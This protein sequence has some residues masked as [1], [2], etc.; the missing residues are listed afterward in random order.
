MVQWQGEDVEHQNVYI[1]NIHVKTTNELSD[2]FL[3]NI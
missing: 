2:D 1:T 3:Y